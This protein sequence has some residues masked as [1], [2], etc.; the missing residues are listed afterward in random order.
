MIDVKNPLPEDISEGLLG[1]IRKEL[2]AAVLYRNCANYCRC[3]GF[4][5]AH[6]FFSKQASEEFNDHAHLLQHYLSNRGVEYAT[7]LPDESNRVDGLRECFKEGYKAESGLYAD[8][9]ELSIA[10]SHEDKAT[11]LLLN[12]F[13]ATQADEMAKFKI[14]RQQLEHVKDDDLYFWQESV[15]RNLLPNPESPEN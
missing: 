13:I 4:I 6:K 8:Y 10:V 2:N 1:M 9:Q 15:F 7:P 5:G 11:H 12:K 3:Y 14:F